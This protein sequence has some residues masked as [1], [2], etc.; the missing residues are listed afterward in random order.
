MSKEILDKI[1]KRKN[2][3]TSGS[4]D[5]QQ[6]EKIALAWVLRLFDDYEKSLRRCVLIEKVKKKKSRNKPSRRIRQQHDNIMGQITRINI[7]HLRDLVR[8]ARIIAPESNNNRD[9]DSGDGLR[10]YF[11]IT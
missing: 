2:N 7:M 9:N 5:A 11:D 6:G 4:W 1:R 10:S 3:P 8:E